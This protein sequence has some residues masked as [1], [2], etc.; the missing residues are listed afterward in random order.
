M[1]RGCSQQRLLL[2]RLQACGAWGPSM[3]MPRRPCAACAQCVDGRTIA[4]RLA[5]KESA[6]ELRDC[7]VLLYRWRER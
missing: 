3:P 7:G 6:D 4:G 2:G 5:A 1:H